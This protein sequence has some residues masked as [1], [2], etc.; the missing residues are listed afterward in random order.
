MAVVCELLDDDPE[1]LLTFELVDGNMQP[2]EHGPW[3]P[4]LY[5]A[6]FQGQIEVV[7][8]ELCSAAGDREPLSKK[9]LDPILPRIANRHRR[10][11]L[12]AT[13][14][15]LPEHGGPD[16][17]RIRRRAIGL[18]DAD[19]PDT[20]RP[21]GDPAEDYEGVARVYREAEARRSDPVVAVAEWLGGTLPEGATSGWD[22]SEYPRAKRLVREAHRR[23]LL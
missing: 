10:A 1:V 11:V 5:W 16:Y 12:A 22:N 23:G 21:R 20:G 6:Q 15:D 4:S 7:G 2:D 9:H 14:Q 19:R 8:L 13:L 17:A 18:W 3:R